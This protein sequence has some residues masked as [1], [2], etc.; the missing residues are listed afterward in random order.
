MHGLRAQKMMEVQFFI[1]F[2]YIYLHDTPSEP[3]HYL[4]LPPEQQLK[5]L[6]TFTI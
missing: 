5:T 6:D 1:V 2:K 4:S 3:L